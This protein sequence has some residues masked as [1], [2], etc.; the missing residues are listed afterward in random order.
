MKL[1]ILGSGT[2]VPS[3]ERNSS[4]YWVEAGTR[5]VRLDCGAGTVHAMGR[6]GL[7]WE[8][9]THQVVTHFHID[10]CGELAAL[11][12]AFKYGRS[13]PRTEPLALVGPKGLEFLL[14]GLIGQYRMRLLEQDFPVDVRELD[15]GASLDLGDGV[16]LRVE[17]TDHTAES[18]AVRVDS[19]GRSLGYT[20]DAAPSDG[21][22]A[23]FSGVDALVCECSFV[24]DTRGT[25]HM[26]ADDVAALASAAGARRLV[27]THFYFDPEAERVAERLARGFSGPITIARD[28][29]TIDVGR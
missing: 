16:A 21:L 3:G 22:A 12:F 13:N 23:F 15:P 29:D 1:T 17:K 5:R 6:Y 26:R 10:H 2:C 7:P 4:G 27:A 11:L 24:D 14:M 19:G 9:L 18:L 25:K 28:G 8:T 20:G